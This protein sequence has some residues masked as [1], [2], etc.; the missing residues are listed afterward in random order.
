MDS[1]ISWV[2]GKKLLRKRILEEFPTERKFKRYVEVFGGAGWVLFSR[3]RH[4]EIEVYNDRNGELVNLFR[5][6]KYHPEALQK[7][8]EWVLTSREI[9]ELYKRTEAAGLTDIQRAARFFVLI[10]ES[11][12]S[13]MGTFLSGPKDMGKA[14]EYLSCIS[15]RLRM[16]VLENQD[17]SKII[18]RYDSAETLF[19]LDPPYFNAERQYQEKFAKQDHEQL[20]SLLSHIKGMF[21]LSYNDCEE[22]RKLYSR[23]KILPVNRSNNLNCCYEAGSRY[24]E[25]I[26]KNY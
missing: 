12:G 2:G 9:F 1:F 16:T 4:A 18:S 21:L 20:Y 26:I 13:K 6:V 10:K 8:L 24:A 25:L 11:Y 22:I 14:V 19:Y 23:Y 7:E 3:D 5:C 17:Y 15:K